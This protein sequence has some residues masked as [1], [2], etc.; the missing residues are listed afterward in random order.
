MTS[1]RLS[2]EK[3]CTADPVVHHQRTKW[4]EKPRF[5][6][7][8]IRSDKRSKRT[9]PIWSERGRTSFHLV[10]TTFP[11][12]TGSDRTCLQAV[13]CRLESSTIVSR[14]LILRPRNY[15]LKWVIL[16]FLPL[17][18]A[19]FVSY[20]VGPWLELKLCVSNKRYFKSLSNKSASLSRHTAIF[21]HE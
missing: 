6:C 21:V 7:Q 3:I 20:D 16:A 12:S 8:R 18:V 13:F 5:C 17:H 10:R 14:H 2:R 15:K 1:S 4:L 9:K 19:P 11:V